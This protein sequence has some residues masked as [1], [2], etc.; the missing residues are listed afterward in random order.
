M[1]SVQNFLSTSRQRLNLTETDRVHGTNLL[2]PVSSFLGK[3]GTEMYK[4]SLASQKSS[5]RPWSV[6]TM[7][8]FKA[9]LTSSSFF[10]F[11]IFLLGSIVKTVVSLSHYTNY[12][13]YKK[14]MKME[15]K[16]KAS[17]PISSTS[18]LKSPISEVTVL[19]QLEFKMHNK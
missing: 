7:A 19:P 17:N 5:H 10:F 1:N 3:L 2:F 12:K 9:S 13:R 16:M 4:P 11:L 8:C 18:F 6:Y 15:M 14:N